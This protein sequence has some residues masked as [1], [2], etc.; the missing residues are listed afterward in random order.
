[1]RSRS[2]R[3]CTENV[4]CLVGRPGRSARQRPTYLDVS[5]AA[6][7]FGE[8]RPGPSRHSAWRRGTTGPQGVLHPWK[9]EKAGAAGHASWRRQLTTSQRCA[10]LFTP[11]AVAERTSTSE[12]RAASAIA[13]VAWTPTATP[14]RAPFV[15]VRCADR[16]LLIGAADLRDVD[17]PQPFSSWRRDPDEGTTT[18]SRAARGGVAVAESSSHE[19]LGVKAVGGD[20]PRPRR[21]AALRL[22]RLP[23]DDARRS[24]RRTRCATRWGGGAGATRPTARA[25]GRSATTRRG[26]RRQRRMRP[27]RRPPTRGRRRRRRA[28]PIRTCSSLPRSTK[29]SRSRSSRAASSTRCPRSATSPRKSGS[30]TCWRSRARRLHLRVSAAAEAGEEEAFERVWRRWRRRQGRRRRRGGGV[31][32]RRRRRRRVVVALRR[33]GGDLDAAALLPRRSRGRSEQ[34]LSG[35]RRRPGGAFAPPETWWDLLERATTRA[36]R[37][38]AGPRARGGR[39]TPSPPRLRQKLAGGA[40]FRPPRAH[41]AR[42]S[43]PR[44][45]ARRP[46]RA[47]HGSVALAEPARVADERDRPARADRCAGRRL[48]EIGGGLQRSPRRR[49]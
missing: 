13:L 8:R 26:R 37:A 30:R 21:R 39:R 44:S 3:E 19:H 6:L 28:G 38:A 11:L 16:E 2:A 4:N 27:T 34:S 23:V 47:R 29:R 24:R 48:A 14:R 7:T 5:H 31:R 45:R 18:P 17:L 40:G 49:P 1:M 43:S 33:P 41:L 15:G 42:S 46:D 10:P 22:A 12:M 32:R 36:A 9:Q 20:V 25:G 35:S